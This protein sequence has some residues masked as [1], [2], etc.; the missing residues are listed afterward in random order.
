MAGGM[1]FLG[2]AAQFYQPAQQLYSAFL[3]KPSIQEFRADPSVKTAFNVGGNLIGVIGFERFL[4][5]LF[6]YGLKLVI[7]SRLVDQ[8]I[9]DEMVDNM[10]SRVP[11]DSGALLNGITVDKSS[12]LITVSASSVHGEDYAPFVEY[13][14]GDNGKVADDSF[15]EDGTSAGVPLH[16]GG[17]HHAA[18]PPEPFF[19]Q[20]AREGLAAH[21]QSLDEAINETTHEEGF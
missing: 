10:K 9:G 5:A 2:T 4:Q 18:T 19:W 20:S 14:T 1:R 21:R 8:R 15:F 17:R 6:R 13:G 16:S 11:V 7:K 12:D 3:V